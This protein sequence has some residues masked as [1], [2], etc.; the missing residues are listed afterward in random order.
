M[1]RSFQ[2]ILITFLYVCKS[3]KNKIEFFLFF[4]DLMFVCLCGKLKS[5]NHFE[6]ILEE[7]ILNLSQVETLFYTCYIDNKQHQNTNS[8]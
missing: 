5:I 8:H 4:H 1:S 2:I 7:I 3:N 6:V